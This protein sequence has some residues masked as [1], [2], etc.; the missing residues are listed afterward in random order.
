MNKTLDAIMWAA[1]A[2]A[3]LCGFAT[4]VVTGE[5]HLVNSLFNQVLRVLP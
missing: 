5:A 1:F 2:L 3:L 4:G